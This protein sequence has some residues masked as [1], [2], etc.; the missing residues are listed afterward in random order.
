MMKINIRSKLSYKNYK[1]KAK[2]KIIINNKVNNNKA[3]SHYPPL[4]M[5]KNY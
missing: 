4:E 3:M 5:T 1:K 2:L